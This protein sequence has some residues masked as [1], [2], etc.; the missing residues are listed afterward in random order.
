MT[1]TVPLST[2]TGAVGPSTRAHPETPN[3]TFTASAVTGPD[4]AQTV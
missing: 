3:T 2:V 4:G 1:N